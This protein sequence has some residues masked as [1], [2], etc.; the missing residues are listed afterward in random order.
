MIE[1]SPEIN[2]A[3]LISGVI[4]LLLP[5]HVLALVWGGLALIVGYLNLGPMVLHIFYQKAYALALNYSLAAVPLFI[6]MGSMLERSGIVGRL[7][8]ALYLWLGG[9][10]GGLAI[11]TVLIGT[12]MAACVG[13]IAAS[14]TM[15]ALVALPS[16]VRKGYDKSLASGACCVGGTLGILIPPSIMLVIYG[17]MAGISVGKLFMAAIFPGLTLSLLYCS[18]I[19]LRCFFQPQLGPSVPAEERRVPFIRKTTALLVALGP[20]MVLV[21]SVLGVIFLGIAPPTE[22]AAIGAFTATLLAIAYRSFS[23]QTLS[24]VCYTTLKITSFALLIGVC[25]VG[26]VGVFMKLG[27]GEVI[28]NLILAAPGGRWGAFAMIMLIVFLL[29]MVETWLGILFI[30]VPIITPLAPALGFDPLW[31]AMMVCINL[32]MAFNT[33]P[34]AA[35]IFLVR[36]IAGPELGITMGEIIRGVV[37]FVLLIMV[38]LG[39]CVLFPQIILWLPGQM[40]R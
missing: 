40:I 27:C 10:R 9:F 12:I 31:F 39:L 33:P 1:L 18:Y 20:T 21:M 14:V 13:I 32:Q 4:L 29:G 7:Y 15:L 3:I 25:A 16:M 28:Q 17:P 6:F 11:V 8:D 24:E 38:G 35:A 30:M 19:A 37:P 34:V 5:G 36:G 26:F 23:W 2:T 22:A